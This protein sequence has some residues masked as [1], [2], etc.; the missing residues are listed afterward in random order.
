MS[1]CLTQFTVAELLAMSE[2]EKRAACPPGPDCDPLGDIADDPF[3]NFTVDCNQINVANLPRNVHAYRYQD[4]GVG[5]YRELFRHYCEFSVDAVTD[6]RGIC[7]VWALSNVIDDGAAWTANRDQALG[8]FLLKINDFNYHLRLRNHKTNATSILEISSDTDYSAVITRK[9]GVVTVDVY[10]GMVPVGS[11]SVDVDSNDRYRYFYRVNSYDSSIYQTAEFQG[12]TRN[13]VEFLWHEG[14]GGV[15]LGGSADSSTDS[16][17]YEGSGGISLG[18]SA[19]AGLADVQYT[20]EGGIALGGEAGHVL[21]ADNPEGGIAFG[22]A[23]ESGI[24]GYLSSGEGGIALGGE[25]DAGVTDVHLEA[26]GGIAL[27]GE[28]GHA[29][30]ADL[31]EGGIAFGGT[32]S[33]NFEYYIDLN[34]EWNILAP[35]QVDYDFVWDVESSVRYWFRIESECVEPACETTDFNPNDEMCESPAGHIQGEPIGV[36]NKYIQIFPARSVRNLCELI[37]EPI[38]PLWVP[39]FRWRIKSITRYNMTMRKSDLPDGEIPECVTL[40]EEEFCDIP[41]CM[42]FCLDTPNEPN[43]TAGVRVS[44]QDTFLEF[45]PEDPEGGS[46]VG[47]IALGGA[48]EHRGG[49]FFTYVAS[50]GLA[51]G[52]TADVVSPSYQ[53]EAQ[54]GMEFGGS[55]D[56]VSEYYQYESQGGIEFSGSAGDFPEYHYAGEGGI[57]FGG[58]ESSETDWGILEFASAGATVELLDLSGNFVFFDSNPTGLTIEDTEVRVPC[59]C[60]YLALQLEMLNNWSRA[61]GFGDFLQRNSLS[62]P[63]RI[64]LLYHQASRTW[65]KSYH[66]AGMSSDG[67]TQERWDLLFQWACTNE[68]NGQELV[69][70]V[71]RFSTRI[72]KTNL[73][74]GQDF[75]TRLIFAVEKEKA[76][77]LGNLSIAFAVDT[78]SGVV[79]TDN[80][81]VLDYSILYDEIGL[82]KGLQWHKNPYLDITIS[83]VEAE[84]PWPRVDISPLFPEQPLPVPY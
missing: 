72:R 3:G 66:F 49:T 83:E 38:N 37:S 45:D 48:A 58:G 68:V 30:R 46:G 34:S 78:E 12:Y 1:S 62:I 27:G 70:D 21:K 40:T 57:A 74:S 81:D 19:P 69:D 26:E 54:G 16:W 44:M 41:E 42:E 80:G 31:P 5:H 11:I 79:T 71:W 76:C 61:S 59:E 28:A 43:I 25:A 84:G 64:D 14:D 32:A 24:I 39:K 67:T 17:L 55:A 77:R 10:T 36:G 63:E 60:G 9:D 35:M 73:S 2:S 56:V 51:F 75:Q 6:D 7:Y 52:G 22:G 53:Y 15:A 82:F 65:K 50:G 47:G 33:T 20:G 8:L 29:L 18:G 4:K 23:A 13:F